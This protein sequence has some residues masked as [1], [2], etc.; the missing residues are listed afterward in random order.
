MTDQT[1]AIV[2]DLDGTLADSVPLI[3]ESIVGALSL[4]LDDV[5]RQAVRSYIGQPLVVALSDMTGIALDDP[6]IDDMREHYRGAY[7]PLVEAA[8]TALLL[9]G[10]VEMLEDV[11]SLGYAT[12]V[13]TAKTTASAEHLFEHVGIG[14]LIDVLIGTDQVVN[15]KPAPDSGL[16]ALARLGA[17][18]ADTWYVGDATSDMA[19]ATN[20]GM[21]GLGITTGV[22]SRDE[23]L[24]AGARAVV[25]RAEEIV[26]LLAQGRP[27]D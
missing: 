21:P 26:P 1:R 2:F 12:G 8:G 6:R 9:P 11:R 20:V 17:R 7:Q 16:L 24:A 22:A 19:M 23:L 14:H 10:V 18:P 4:H 15:G 5:D 25:D 13:V 3:E 27:G